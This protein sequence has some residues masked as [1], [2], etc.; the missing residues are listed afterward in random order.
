MTTFDEMKK[1][2]EELK[3]IGTVLDF[4]KSLFFENGKLRTLNLTIILPSG[5]G[6]SC[7]ADIVAL[8]YHYYGFHH[9]T[10]QQPLLRTGSLD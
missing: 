5:T 2:Q 1:A 8:Q 9:S 7:T 6:G 4:E 10:T 3:K